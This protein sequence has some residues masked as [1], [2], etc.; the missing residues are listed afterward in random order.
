MKQGFRKRTIKIN[1][2][3]PNYLQFVQKLLSKIFRLIKKIISKKIKK[4]LKKI[5]SILKKMAE[6]FSTFKIYYNLW[7]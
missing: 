5:I 1:Y 7:F 3:F 4:I 6:L 2:I